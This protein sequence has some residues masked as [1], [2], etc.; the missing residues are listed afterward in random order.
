MNRSERLGHGRWCH[1]LVT[2]LAVTL[3]ISGMG[4]RPSPAAD[5]PRFSYGVPL[6][7]FSP[8]PKFRRDAPQSGRSPVVAVDSG[9]APWVFQTGKGVFS[10]PVIDGDGTVYI[11]SGD[12]Y[13][14]AI[15]R[16]GH[17][18]WKFLTSEI[19]DSAALLDDQGRV[20]FGSGDGRL[21]ALDRSTGEMQWAFL[22]DDP[23]VNDAFIRWFEGNV[24]IAPD[25]VL[26]A[27]NDNFCTY[28]VSRAR[29]ERLWCFRTRDQTWSLPALDP[30]TN[31]LLIGNNFPFLSNTFALNAANGARLWSAR[32]HGSVVASPL[33]TTALHRQRAVVGAF[34]GH[35]RAYDPSS[36]RELWQRALRDHVYASPAEAAD[37]LIIQPDADGTVYALR[38]QDGTVRWAFDTRE[39]IRSS[40]AIDGNGNIYV[41]TGE[42]KLL[43]LNPDG[44]LRWAMRLIDDP[45]D[46]LNSSPALGA[47]AVVLGGES[48]G[49]FGVP[50]DYCLRPDAASDARCL[51]G[52]SEGWPSDGASL[53]YTTSFGR[54]LS[55]PPPAIEA[56]QSLTFSLVVRAHDDTQPSLLDSQSVHVTLD[57]PTAAEVDVS[58]DRR[59][60][61]VVPTASFNAEALSVRIEAGYLSAGPTGRYTDT[62]VDPLRRVSGRFAFQLRRHASTGFQLTVPQHPGDPAT[63][64]DLYRLAAP[65][66]TILPS[67]NQIGFDSIHYRI[68][69]VEGDERHAVG[70][71]IG[72]RLADDGAGSEVDPDSRVRFPIEIDLDGDLL[73]MRNEAGFTVEFNGFPLPFE[74]FRVAARVDIHGAAIDHA[75]INAKTTCGNIDFY[76][77]FL[78][79]LGYCNPSTDLLNVVGAAELRPH[80]NGV[81]PPPRPAG[82]VDFGS[83]ATSVTATIHGSTW[84]AAEHNVGLLLVDARTGRPLPLDY[85]QQ[86][87]H[88]VSADGG[89]ESV[90][91]QFP[92]GSAHGAVRAYAMLDDYPAA[93]AALAL[94]E[95][96]P[97][98]VAATYR[99]RATVGAARAAA[100]RRM[101][102]ALLALFEW[103]GT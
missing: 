64:W 69:L 62:R 38:P 89:I 68:G 54:Y 6:D 76:G 47:D 8:W 77:A 66:P 30:A 7:P 9:R 78:Q 48:G 39:P 97:L 32:A 71:V 5:R 27:P 10:S 50:Y 93:S 21:Y 46:D 19:I 23:S 98:S 96:P 44:T 29:G 85:A 101:R 79:R 63:E 16:D 18:R 14:Y 45:R 28:A 58:G 24:A 81:K 87:T 73:T 88:T 22:A 26:Y 74:F 102:Q 83:N 53:V 36:G 84:R 11:G 75:A 34:D 15:D 31:V 37:G 55:V 41:G 12:H 40:P 35:V 3:L 61:T 91:V 59:F 25:G 13:F 60:V 56:N 92:P 99:L 67:Y 4:S 43:V 95:S 51:T 90:T 42:G 80:G 72:G 2:G 70:W 86:T 100:E 94:P 57:P 65:L 20:I 103:W 17:L 82:D 1:R 33:S 49:V 52:Q